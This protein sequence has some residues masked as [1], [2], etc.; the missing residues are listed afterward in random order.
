MEG[1]VAPA[2]E[3]RRHLCK[4]GLRPVEG[5]QPDTLAGLEASLVQNRDPAPQDVLGLPVGQ[6]LAVHPEGDAG[7][8]AAQDREDDVAGRGRLVKHRHSPV[9]PFPR[10][11]R[12]ERAPVCARPGPALSAILV[13]AFPRPE[14]C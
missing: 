14:G 6:V 13:R 9:L 4:P 3:R 1:G 10:W 12:L 7:G 5:E 11:W 2:G 8:E